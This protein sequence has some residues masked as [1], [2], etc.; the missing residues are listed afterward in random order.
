MPS[1][2]FV[3]SLPGHKQLE[4]LASLEVFTEAQALCGRISI[5]Q[6]DLRSSGELWKAHTLADLSSG[7]VLAIHSG[8]GHPSTS[9]DFTVGAVVT[10]T[11]GPDVT[12]CAGGTTT[13]FLAGLGV[14]NGR[15]VAALPAQ[16]PALAAA[17][18]L[19][20]WDGQAA[21]VRDGYLVTYAGSLG[22]AQAALM[23]L[24]SSGHQ[25]VAE[26][27]A[28]RLNIGMTA[29]R[30]GGELEG[31]RQASHPALQR[32]LEALQR[33]PL[34]PW[35]SAAV[36]KVAC[37]SERHLQRLFRA[38][39]A[40]GVLDFLQRLRLE[41]AMNHFRS[42]PH[43]TLDRVAQAAG[44]SSTQ[45]LRRIWRRQFGEPPSALRRQMTV[46]EQARSAPALS[47]QD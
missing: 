23:A 1:E 28:K 25:E 16:R 42:E 15:R 38:E 17:Y 10:R 30:V 33:D 4:L 9:L 26:R 19:V 39:F 5:S 29:E 8:P 14:L 27:V 6:V 44:F 31:Q 2:F 24:R 34:R 36:A 18:P 11:W 7:S 43:E 35:T 20:R 45:Q 12:L 32:A 3:L 46:A 40:F 37:V 47:R 22:A 21:C 41:R 13:Q